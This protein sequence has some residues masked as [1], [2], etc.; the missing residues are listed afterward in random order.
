MTTEETLPECI[1]K[2]LISVEENDLLMSEITPTKRV[3]NLILRLYRRYETDHSVF[4]R[5]FEIMKDVNEQEGGYMDHIIERLSAEPPPLPERRRPAALRERERAVLREN[6]DR[7]LS[8]LDVEEILPELVSAL[9]VD[10][11]EC[12]SV[13]SAP[14]SPKRCQRLLDLLHRR[15]SEDFHKF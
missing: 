8:S 12:A 7:L 9:V 6:N 5:L 2:H 4:S 13:R 14:E 11:E 1:A 15:G 10:V 3:E